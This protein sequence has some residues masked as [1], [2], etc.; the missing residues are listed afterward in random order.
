MRDST[1]AI[2]SVLIEPHAKGN[3]MVQDD[4]LIK[5]LDVVGQNEYVGWY[6]GK[7]EDA[8]TMVWTMPNEPILFSEFGAEAKFGVHSGKN[9]RWAEE[10]QVNV[11]EHQ[12]AMINRIPQVRGV[13]PWVLMDFR[14]SVRNIPKLQDGYNRKGL[15]AEDGEKRQ[16]FFLVQKTCAN[17]LLRRAEYP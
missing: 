9:E 16:A 12:F 5:A 13:V 1:W 7:P 11:F 17:N 8:G 6:E 4:P 10:Q 15:I 2:T 3:Q 14:S